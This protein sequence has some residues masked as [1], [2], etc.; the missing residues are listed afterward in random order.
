M[1][2]T[3]SCQTQHW[4]AWRKSLCHKIQSPENA[5]SQFNVSHSGMR[6]HRLFLQSTGHDLQGFSTAALSILRW[7]QQ[8]NQ[9]FP[10]Y[11]PETHDDTSTAST[12]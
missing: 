5:Y 10:C 4:K 9:S 8:L 6:E 1:A 11:N 2:D 3:C 12:A 7:Q